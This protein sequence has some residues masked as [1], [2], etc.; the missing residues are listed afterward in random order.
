MPRGLKRGDVF[1]YPFP[2][3][4]KN[5]PVVIL[6]GNLSIPLLTKVTVAPIT[7]TWRGVPTEVP[8]DETDGMKA[9]CAVNLHNLMTVPQEHL[10]NW[11]TT[12]SPNRMAVICEAL[13]FAV[14][15]DSKTT[16][17]SSSSL[18]DA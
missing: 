9:P 18:I 15:C 10:G 2:Y 8:L 17:L 14:D 16:P 7:T 12:L 5:R 11:V 1:M 4:D 6:T 13:R 3:Q